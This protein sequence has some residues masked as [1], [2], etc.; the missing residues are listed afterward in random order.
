VKAFYTNVPIT[1]ACE[2]IKKL[3]AKR[4]DI[5]QQVELDDLD[6]LIRI[7]MNNNFFSF[8]NQTYKQ[9]QGF[10]MG[11]SCSPTVANLY[12]AYQEMCKSIHRPEKL[13]RSWGKLVCYLRYIDDIHGIFEGTEAQLNRLLNNHLQFTPLQ[14]GYTYSQDSQVFLDTE[15]FF[16]RTQGTRDLRLHT[17]LFQKPMNK[18]LYI[19]WSSGHPDHVK[20]AFIKA[21]MTRFATI[22]SRSE[23]FEAIK[24]KFIMNLRRR[25]YPE[26]ILRIWAK[27][28][29]FLD[30]PRI[31]FSPK[32]SDD[33]RPLML[34]SE[35]NAIWDDISCN[36]MLQVMRSC[37]NTG[38]VPD[39]LNV[40]LIKSLRRT[41]NTFDLFNTWNKMILEQNSPKRHRLE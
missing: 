32:E 1:H 28:V 33:K 36:E 9:I 13:P 37:W 31:L 24:Q 35:Y 11:T 20:K 6:I 34:S 5:L 26:Y 10:A 30:R 27:Q 29:S 3:C 16:D 22:C 39:S 18:Y 4:E 38:P 17:K 21:E 15:I 8:D 40:P 14:V 23:D 41:T 19:P 25:G 7:V 12:L 2:N